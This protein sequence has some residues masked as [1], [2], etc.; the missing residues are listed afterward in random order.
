MEFKFNQ[1]FEELT[2]GWR[3]LAFIL[4]K[5]LED[6]I[7]KYQDLD[8]INYGLYLPDIIRILDANGINYKLSFPTENGTY[9]IFYAY[10]LETEIFYHY[11]LYKDGYLYDSLQQDKEKLTIS[12]LKTR[13]TQNQPNFL[14]IAKIQTIEII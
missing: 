12:E 9:L 11:V 2:C 3:C 10:I 6:L 14:N 4:N 7:K 8:P 1:N 5:S 13:I